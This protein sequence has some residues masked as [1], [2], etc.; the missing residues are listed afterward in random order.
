MTPAELQ[1][2]I[3]MLA[4]TPPNIRPFVDAA[5]KAAVGAQSDIAR[6]NQHSNV[7]IA[8]ETGTDSVTVR[9][10]TLPTASRGGSQISPSAAIKAHLDYQMK[11][12]KIIFRNQTQAAL[13]G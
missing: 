5:N 8:V 9:W 12:A 3:S 11:Q 13:S 4:E 6:L 10:A 1:T 7:N 2:H